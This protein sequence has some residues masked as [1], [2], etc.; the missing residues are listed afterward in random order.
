MRRGIGSKNKGRSFENKMANLFTEWSKHKFKRVPMSGGWEKEVVSGDIFCVA[1]YEKSQDIRF[2]LS[3]EL[4]C[5]EAWDFEHLFKG[6][7]KNPI[8]TW[9]QQST[10]DS[11]IS[12]KIPALIFTKNYQPDFILLRLSILKKLN[13]LTKKTWEEFFYIHC[14]LGGERVVVLLLSDFLGYI[15]FSTLLQLT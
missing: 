7:D 3:L 15:N 8:Y 10:E 5:T 2:P 9:W 11:K 6:S 12:K 13:K 1:E 14:F 4:K